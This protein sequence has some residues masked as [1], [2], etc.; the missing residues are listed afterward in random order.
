MDFLEVHCS[1]I[2]YREIGN[3][4]VHLSSLKGHLYNMGLFSLL[5]MLSKV[6]LPTLKTLV[7]FFFVNTVKFTGIQR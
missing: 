1:Y 4:S 5:D 2:K 3:G 6:P 7:L